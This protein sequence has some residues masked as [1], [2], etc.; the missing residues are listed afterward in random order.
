MK[1]EVKGSKGIED[2]L[3]GRERKTTIL[4]RRFCMLAKALTIVV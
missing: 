3:V 2:K 4:Q 1:G